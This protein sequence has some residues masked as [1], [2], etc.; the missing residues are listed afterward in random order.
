MRFYLFIN[1]S[2]NFCTRKFETAPLHDQSI[3]L[4]LV[5]YEKKILQISIFFKKEIN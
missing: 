5:S 1:A 4:L 2:D 3:D